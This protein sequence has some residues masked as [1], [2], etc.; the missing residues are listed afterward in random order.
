MTQNKSRARVTGGEKYKKL[1]ADK[2]WGAKTNA[3]NECGEQL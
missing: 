1:S 3:E 2:K